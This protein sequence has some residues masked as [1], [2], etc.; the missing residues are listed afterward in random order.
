MTQYGDFAKTYAEGDYTNHSG[1]MAEILPG[2]LS[3][4]DIDAEKILDLACGEGT[5]ARKT[6]GNGYEVKGIDLSEELIQIAREKRDGES[7]E[8]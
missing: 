8:F 6:T 3:E 7:P 4:Y 1:K 2:L 5:F